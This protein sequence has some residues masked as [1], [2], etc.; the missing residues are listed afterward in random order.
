MIIKKTIDGTDAVVKTVLI[1]DSFSPKFRIVTE[2]D[3]KH[4]SIL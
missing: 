3:E 2:N 1:I 4:I